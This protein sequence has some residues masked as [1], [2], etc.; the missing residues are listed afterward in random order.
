[1]QYAVH[2]EIGP[3]F[4]SASNASLGV[5]RIRVMPTKVIDAWNLPPQHPKLNSLY[6]NTQSK[7]RFRLI[8]FFF[9]P[10][11]RY[12]AFLWS[13]IYAYKSGRDTNSDIP[14]FKTSET[15]GRL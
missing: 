14:R 15:E 10:L 2:C 3:Q 7:L 11:L 9:L 6:T 12:V 13:G 5:V 4:Q 8:N 1:M